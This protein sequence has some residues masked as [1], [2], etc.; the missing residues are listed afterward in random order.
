MNLSN[1]RPRTQFLLSILVPLLCILMGL[2]LLLPVVNAIRNLNRDLEQTKDSIYEKREMISQA[3]QAAGGRPLALAVAVPDEQE[4]IVFLRQLAGLAEASHV[5]LAAVRAT[6]PPPLPQAA[7]QAGSARGT[8][9]PPAPAAAVSGLSGER[10]VVP[11]TVRELTDEVTAEGNFAEIL[12][13]IMRLEGF[14]R[15]LSVSKCKLSEG[16]AVR[17]P[18]LR[19]VFTLSRFVGRPEMETA[20][21]RPAAGH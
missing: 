18:E 21:S 8:A 3:E 15:I 13:F 11:P 16:G 14:D 2:V 17:Y 5:T 10:P 9:A 19:A 6:S 12:G 20:P 1:L 4:P 7:G